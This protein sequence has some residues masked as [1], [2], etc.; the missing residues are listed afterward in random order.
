MKNAAVQH[1]AATQDEPSAGGAP[2]T[3][4]RLPQSA[5][6]PSPPP[7][8]ED[9]APATITINDRR[10]SASQDQQDEPAG[11]KK[12]SYVAELEAKLE[13]KETR[14]QAT[15]AQYKEALDE[16]ASTKVRLNRDIS[17][18]IEAGKKAILC[19]L[20]EVVDNLERAIDTAAD[21]PSPL[22]EGICMVR[23]Q[24]LAKLAHLGVNKV[25]AMGTRF[26]PLHFEAIS[27][28]PVKDAA[29]DGMVVGVVR[30][31][32]KI[33][34]QTLRHGMVAVGQLQQ[35]ADA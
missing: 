16:F 29:Q 11:Q 17:K 2:T 32:Y 13:E 1:A 35:K 30:T 20:L 24:F 18:E 10:H 12:P 5:T 7:A 21:Q 31:A 4:E 26:D 19:D 3:E 33:G 27:M 8:A 6:E 34:E 15:L 22:R 14:L 28:V 9:A 23:D 25:V